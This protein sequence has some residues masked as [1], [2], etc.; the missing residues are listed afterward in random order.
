MPEQTTPPILEGLT[1]EETARYNENFAFLRVTTKETP[2]DKILNAAKELEGLV[3]LQ[4]IR[5]GER[6]RALA[7]LESNQLA[8]A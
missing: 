5:N 6:A 1:P 7:L 4:G 3:K 8:D 2:V